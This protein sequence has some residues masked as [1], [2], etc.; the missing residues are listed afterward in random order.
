M[1]NIFDELYDRS[2]N[3]AMKGVDL[4]KHIIARNNILLAYRTIKSN[5]GSKIAGTDGKT[6]EDFKVESEDELINMVRTN[7]TDYRPDSVRRVEIPKSN[8]KTRPLGIPTMLDRLI[9]QMFKQ[10][11]EPICEAKFYNHSYGFRPNRSAKHAMAR[12]QTLVNINKLHYVV[13]IDIKGF[14]DNVN[15]NKLIKQIHTIGIQDKRVQ[16]I[17]RKM[18]GAPIGGIGVPVKGTPQGGILSPLLSNIVLNDL[19]HWISSQWE[20]MKTERSYHVTSKHRSLRKTRLKEMFIVRYADDFKVF[21]RDYKTAYKVYH[22]IEKYLKINLGL[23]ISPDK[24]K[25]TNLRKSK[26]EFLGFTLQAKKKRSKHVAITHVSPKK[27]QDIAERARKLIREIQ[28]NRNSK[29]VNN[30]NSFVMGVKNYFNG[31]THVTKDFNEIAYRISRTL[32]NRLKSVGKYGIPIK[33]SETYKLY[34]KN[35]Y[36]TYKTFEIVGVHLHP[37]AC[38]QTVHN[39]NFSQ[40]INNYTKIGREK[41]KKLQG[42][43]TRELRLMMHN[44]NEEQ[45]IEYIDNRLSKYSMQKG[46]CG[47]TGEFLYS[48]DVHCHHIL[49]RALGGTDEFRNLVIV[50]NQVHRLIHATTDETIERYMDELKLNGN[51][52]EKLNRYRKKCNL[53]EVIIED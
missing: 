27:K 1:Q 7:L 45:T 23:E 30:Y 38:I 14:F 39:M 33:P 36:R 46:K 53:V 12:S 37:I 47:V 32:Y 17:I 11:L 43:I 35:S 49:P 28:K 31:A 2:K 16:R 42:N 20:N 13:D 52:L 26:S 9:Q 5:T 21:V 18:L 34:N 15:H 51:Q 25:I 22:A 41:H 29:A 44:I 48:T 50:S 19:D 40:D 3:N 6:I 10:V 24:S 4:Y 8:G